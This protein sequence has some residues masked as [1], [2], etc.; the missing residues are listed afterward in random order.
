MDDRIIGDWLLTGGWTLMDRN[1]E[2]KTQRLKENFQTQS[3]T[4][5]ISLGKDVAL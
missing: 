5:Y 3:L 4:I 1:T 2:K